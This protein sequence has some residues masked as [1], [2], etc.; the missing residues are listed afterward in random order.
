M[1]ADIALKLELKLGRPTFSSFN[2]VHPC[3][4]SQ[5]TDDRKQFQLILIWN[6]I[7]AEKVF[8]R[9]KKSVRFWND[10]SF[11]NYISS[12]GRKGEVAGGGGGGE[13]VRGTSLYKPY[14]YVPP[15]CA[16]LV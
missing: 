9:C 14:R 7:D 1:L 16:V 11:R 2:L 8:N 10:R 13:E 15:H 4:A 12:K 6:S 5:A 3:H